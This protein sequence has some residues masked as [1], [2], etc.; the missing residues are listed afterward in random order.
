M[1]TNAILDNMY[2]LWV[3]HW[4]QRESLEIT[5]DKVCAFL[6][7]LTTNQ[8]WLDKLRIALE[9]V[10]VIDE[11]E[12]AEDALD[13]YNLSELYYDNP[14]TGEST[15]TCKK[16]VVSI[17]ALAELMSKIGDVT[18]DDKILREISESEETGLN[19]DSPSFQWMKSLVDEDGM[20]DVFRHYYPNA[21]ARWVFMMSL[22]V[23]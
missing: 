11:E 4:Q 6:M 14:R 5:V 21:E 22:L 15:L 20:V 9:E 17:E 16:N 8:K 12:S 13:Y 18:W 19:P 10:T 3:K 7:N 23:M 1:N 2:Q